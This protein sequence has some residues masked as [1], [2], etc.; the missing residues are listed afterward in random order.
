MTL[1]IFIV[2]YFAAADFYSLSYYLAS[3]PYLMGESDSKTIFDWGKSEYIELISNGIKE[4][5]W[6]R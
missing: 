2:F 6:T 5:L 1:L 4:I 3:T